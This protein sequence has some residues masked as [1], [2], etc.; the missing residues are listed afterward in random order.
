MLEAVVGRVIEEELDLYRKQAKIAPPPTKSLDD[1]QPLC[2][3]MLDLMQGFQRILNRLLDN[4]LKQ[5]HLSIPRDVLNFQQTKLTSLFHLF[6]CKTLIVEHQP[7]QI[8]K[9][10]TKYV[11][12]NLCGNM[13]KMSINLNIDFLIHFVSDG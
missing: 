8:V 7:Q 9:I 13:L 2:E 3:L 5:Q 11:H 4:V 10:K 1:I 6:L 12:V